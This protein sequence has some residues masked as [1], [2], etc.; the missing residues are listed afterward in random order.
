MKN[1]FIV[2]TGWVIRD[3]LDEYEITPKEFSQK[4]GLDERVVSNLLSGNQCLTKEIALALEDVLPDIPSSYWLNYESKYNEYLQEEKKQ[5]PLNLSAEQ[6]KN[7]SKRFKFSE[8]F[9]GLNLDLQTQAREMLK[10]LKINSFDNFESEYNDLAINFM[11]DGGEAEAIAIWINLSREEIDIQN[12]DISNIEFTPDKLFSALP[13]I[14]NIAYNS[15]LNSSLISAR[16]QLNRLGI[17]LVI[18]DAITNSRVRG[19]L[20]TYNNH[21]AI[22]LSNRFKTHDHTWF[23]LMHEI[24]HLLKHYKPEI[25]MISYE[26]E[27]DI[28]KKEQEANE[29]ARDF[30]INKQEYIN[31]LNQQKLD[32]KSIVAFAETQNIL[33]GILVARLQHDGIVEYGKFEHLKNRI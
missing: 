10:L 25:T 30:F 32:E 15:D 33:P 9:K 21:P 31:F 7:I 5:H 3:Y 8:V 6:L 14:K 12:K 13:K 4:L 29:F 1:N 24:G 19:A 2:P 23:A 18:C 16:K 11:E 27:I 26:E 20:E 17:Y 22:Y 28:S